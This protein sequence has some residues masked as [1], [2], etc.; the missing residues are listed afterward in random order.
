[1]CSSLCATL[2]F[3]RWSWLRGRS[4]GAKRLCGAYLQDQIQRSG[5]NI[6]G[7][8]SGGYGNRLARSK[9]VS[10]KVRPGEERAGEGKVKN[11]CS[12]IV[13]QPV[14]TLIHCRSPV[15]KTWLMI[16]S[17]SL[18][19]QTSSQESRVSQ[20]TLPHYQK[21]TP[22]STEELLVLYF[23]LKSK[24]VRM[25]RAESQQT[26]MEIIQ[27]LTVRPCALFLNA[28][29]L[30]SWFLCFTVRRESMLLLSHGF[31]SASGLETLTVLDRQNEKPL[32]CYKIFKF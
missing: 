4:E 2:P 7:A 8:V 17:W 31:V 9:L 25:H 29:F 32:D 3:V 5:E 22:G 14:W 28:I 15:G 24:W 6:T 1:M 27:Y 26:R 20:R 16:S 18:P 21:S 30:D 19:E 13:T 11:L 12:R 10:V 23:H